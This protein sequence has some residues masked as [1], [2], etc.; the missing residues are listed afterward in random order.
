MANLVSK[1][2]NFGYHGNRVGLA[3]VV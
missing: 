2:A 1:F 3:K